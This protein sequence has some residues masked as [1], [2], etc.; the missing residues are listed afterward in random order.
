MTA[1][2][3]AFFAL[4]LIDCIVICAVKHRL[5]HEIDHMGTTAQTVVFWI[6]VQTTAQNPDRSVICGRIV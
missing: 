2:R 5:S 6:N 4:L 3:K 1:I